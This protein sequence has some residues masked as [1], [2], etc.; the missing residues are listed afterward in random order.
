MPVNASRRSNRRRKEIQFLYVRFFRNSWRWTKPQNSVTPSAMC[1]HEDPLEMTH[2]ACLGMHLLWTL[3]ADI[4]NS[5]SMTRAQIQ[6]DVTLF[7]R[8]ENIV[9]AKDC[10]CVSVSSSSSCVTGA[11]DVLIAMTS[12]LWGLQNALLVPIRQCRS[13]YCHILQSA[14]QELY[15]CIIFNLCICFYLLLIY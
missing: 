14:K 3:P 2:A 13:V 7:W 5:H 8:L 12:S 9:L 15:N 11:L 1:H 4:W 10:N 6:G